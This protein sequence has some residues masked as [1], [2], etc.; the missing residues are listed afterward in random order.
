[1]AKNMDF[2]MILAKI[3][4]MLSEVR[5]KNFEECSHMK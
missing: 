3:I 4:L 1:M 2:S 5:L